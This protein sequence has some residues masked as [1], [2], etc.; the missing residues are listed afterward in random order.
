VSAAKTR[1]EIL[2]PVDLPRLYGPSQ[3]TGRGFR[4]VHMEASLARRAPIEE[5][6]HMG[7]P[8]HH[9][10]EQL[11]PFPVQ[12]H[13]QI[14]QARHVPPRMGQAPDE[15]RLHRVAPHV[16]HH[17]GEGLRRLLG[18]ARRL[19][20]VGHDHGDVE[21]H[22][23]SRQRWE[24]L[25]FAFREAIHE[26]NGLALDIAQVLQP[27]VE[28]IQ[29]SVGRTQHQHAETRYLPRWLCSSSKCRRDDAEGEQDHKP[30][31]VEPHNPVAQF[32][33]AT[34]GRK[35]DCLAC[36]IDQTCCSINSILRGCAGR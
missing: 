7:A 11:K 19:K 26:G 12:L 35:V 22:K 32:I 23:L 31:G 6:G 8:R 2:R 14:H 21:A 3:G 33:V 20:G 24:P 34:R 1:R 28:G 30:D 17:D 5:R 16:H 4:L 15:A 29:S 27:L 36:C 18:R 10:V 9:L 13:T 25:R